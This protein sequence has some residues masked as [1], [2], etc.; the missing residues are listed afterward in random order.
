MRSGIER[1]HNK[2]ALDRYFL[3]FTTGRLYNKRKYNYHAVSK[4][5]GGCGGDS[6]GPIYAKN[7]GVLEVVGIH[8]GGSDEF[9][10][11]HACG[12]YTRFVPIEYF[13]D[14]IFQHVG[15]NGL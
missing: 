3:G 2:Y 9:N 11:K 8:E 13:R 4:Q 15:F 10:K 14:W 6:G 7:N 1:L 5:S 12:K